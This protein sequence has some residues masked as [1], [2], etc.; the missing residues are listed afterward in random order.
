M[1][2]REREAVFTQIQMFSCAVL[3]KVDYDT[4]YLF[5]IGTKTFRTVTAVGTLALCLIT[6]SLGLGPLLALGC[7]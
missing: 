6:N 1:H 4:E 2:G 3:K 5:L 7:L